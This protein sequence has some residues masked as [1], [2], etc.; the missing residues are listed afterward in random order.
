[1]MGLYSLAGEAKA[2]ALDTTVLGEAEREVWR[3]RARDLGF[4][5]ADALVEMGELE[6]AGRH[7]EGLGGEGSVF[8]RALLKV[9]VGDVKGARGL[10]EGMVVRAA[11]REVLNA[12][13]EVADGD[14]AAASTRL[15]ACAADGDATAANNF[16]VVSLYTGHIVTAR[17]TLEDLL[18]LHRHSDRSRHVDD[19]AEAEE[20]EE[21]EDEEDGSVLPATP[22]VLFN[23]CTLYEL[24][25]ERAGE[26]KE[27]LARRMARRTP[28]PEFGGWERARVEF[29]L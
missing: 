11:D 23:L 10:C 16:A 22:G 5:V 8:R 20:V 17:Q 18:H 1:M 29:K 19:E 12:M 27:A 9:R 7:L 6:T 2:K 3:D 4:A 21:E 28:G 15:R 25:T 14:Y 26:R 24:C 13:L